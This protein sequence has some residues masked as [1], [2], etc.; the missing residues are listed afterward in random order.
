ML[1][2][3]NGKYFQVSQGVWGMRLSFVN[4]YMIANRRGVASGWVLIDTGIKGSANK[5]IAMAETLFGPGTRPRA[6]V[7]THGH[8]D[9]SG[10][11]K[12]LLKYWDVPVYAHHMELPYLTGKSNYP[13][14][15]PEVGGGLIS[16]VSGI[17]PTKAIDVRRNTQEIDMYDGIPELPE[18]KVIHT[19][20]HTPGHISLFFP[21]N[22]TLIAGDAFTTTQSE[23][24]LDILTYA[25]KVCGPPKYLTTDWI[26]AAKSVRKLAALQPRIA[27][28]GH[29]PVMRGKE[30]QSELNYLANRF[31]DVA[32]PESGRY[33]GRAAQADENGVRY[34]PSGNGK[35]RVRAAIVVVAAITSFLVV[36]RISKNW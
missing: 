26:A 32:V 33:V 25:K 29:G 22:T 3:T 21:L 2:T 10:S 23:S 9:H 31:E 35:Q 34:I 17:F 19:P 1:N 14:A 7:L 11:L 28:T 15:D 20:G 6:I 12:E 24:V 36:R 18:W 5:I 8:S 4:I 27:A 16:M 13:P 30:L